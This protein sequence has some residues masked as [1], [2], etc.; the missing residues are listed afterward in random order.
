MN[1]REQVG[2][3]VM[4]FSKMGLDHL[5]PPMV[6]T[7]EDHPVSWNLYNEIGQLFF[8]RTGVCTIELSNGA[9][10]NVHVESVNHSNF[11]TLPENPDND[12]ANIR[13]IVISKDAMGFNVLHI[14]APKRRPYIEFAADTLAYIN[15]G[16]SDNFNA[17][18]CKVSS[19]SSRSLFDYLSLMSSNG[20]P[21]IQN[22]WAIL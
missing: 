14:W 17:T 22:H 9:V 13:G 1:K 7:Y 8:G 10:K 2:Q 20:I 3:I 11:M 16:T 21:V 4:Y 12:R 19:E 15:I 6:N 5:L 18:L